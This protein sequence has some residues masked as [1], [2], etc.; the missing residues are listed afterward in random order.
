[1]LAYGDLGAVEIERNRVRCCYAGFWLLSLATIA[2]FSAPSDIIGNRLDDLSESLTYPTTNLGV[3]WSDPV[4]RIG[5]A[6]G[7]AYPTPSGAISADGTPFDVGDFTLTAAGTLH[8]TLRR[9]ELNF[10]S[11]TTALVLR[12]TDNDADTTP[13]PDT[14]AAASAAILVWQHQFSP[15]DRALMGSAVVGEN[16]L[17]SDHAR[18]TAVLVAIEHCSVTGNVVQSP[19]SEHSL[20]HMRGEG[21]IG[22][23]VGGVAITGNV[24]RG[25]SRLPLAGTALE[26]LGGWALL[27]HHEV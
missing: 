7:R 25:N 4:I 6:I 24:L 14:P 18:F 23:A 9:I 16:R 17:A 10:T 5:G 19:T 15:I 13:A 1:M 27:N 21:S 12:V 11:N 20:V 22:T 3:V 8:E 2:L 26:A